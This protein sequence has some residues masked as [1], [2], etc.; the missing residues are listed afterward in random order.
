M[1]EI[2]TLLSSASNTTVYPLDMQTIDVMPEKLD[3]HDALIVATAILLGET[4]EQEV[5][6]VTKD[7]A[8]IQSGLIKTFW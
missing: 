4:H 5:H 6:L 8:I 1:D 3:I 7:E 2:K